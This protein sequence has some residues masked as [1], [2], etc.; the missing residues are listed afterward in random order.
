MGAA[1]AVVISFA[2][3][4]AFQLHLRPGL[5]SVTPPAGRTRT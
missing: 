5:L 3:L 1:R 4:A 2:A